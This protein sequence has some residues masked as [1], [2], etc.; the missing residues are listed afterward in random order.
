MVTLRLVLMAALFAASSAWAQEPASAAL[1]ADAPRAEAAPVSLT[2]TTPSA[3]LLAPTREKRPAWTYGAHLG[4]GIAT[5]IVAAP[6]GLYLATW[7]GHLSNTLLGAAL[8]WL[9][10][11]GFFAPTVTTLVAWLF[12]HG[13][14]PRPAFWLPWVAAVVVNAIALVVGGF[15]GLTVMKPVGMLLY[16][17]IDG[18]AMGG[19]SVGTMHW[20]DP[21]KAAPVTLRSFAPGVCD[22]TMVSL[23]QVEF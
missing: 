22:T 20:L 3:S 6:V 21:R 8:P 23:S 11:G 2:N 16:S 5:G 17:L 15:T 4:L 18:I 12:G 19:M 1:P 10:V 9:L 7:L 14:E 13:D